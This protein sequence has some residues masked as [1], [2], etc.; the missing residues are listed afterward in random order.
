MVFELP[1]WSPHPLCIPYCM[2]HGWKDDMHNSTQS[3]D[4]G[5]RLPWEKGFLACLYFASCIWWL[6]GI[7]IKIW[8]TCRVGIFVA[9]PN[10]KNVAMVGYN[11]GWWS[12]FLINR[13]STA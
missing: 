12:P 2:H 5:W 9:Y 10:P 11:F 4:L 6:D 13:A 7:V 1:L 8:F 3:C